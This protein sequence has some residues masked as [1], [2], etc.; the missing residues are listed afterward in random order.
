M[1]TLPY[2]R[3][4]RSGEPTQPLP[5]VNAPS[6]YE[7]QPSDI[8]RYARI[9]FKRLWLIILLIMIAEG[10]FVSYSLTR[11]PTYESSVRFKIT[12]LPPS[13][14]TLYATT[15]SSSSSDPLSATRADFISVLTS[16]DVAWDTVDSLK[17]PLSGREVEQM[18]SVQETTDSDFIILTVRAGDP[19]QSA[20]VANGLMTNAVKRYGELNAQPLSTSQLFIESQ[21]TD[22]QKS[23]DQAR[24]DLLTF[25]AKNSLGGLDAAINSEVNL[26]RSL[27]LN[28]DQAVAEGD[29]QR[30]QNYQNLVDQRQGDLAQ[31]I[32]LSGQYETLQTRVNQL[33]DTNTLLL[34]KLTEAQLKEN[35][36]RNLDSVQVFGQARVPDQPNPRFSIPIMVLAAAVAMVLGVMLAFLWEYLFP[37]RPK[38]PKAAR[39]AAT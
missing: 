27:Q 37:S 28:H 1:S 33:S 19:Q 23:L 14:V 9:I 4:P 31:M 6:V 35:E 11:P 8:G 36:A 7:N 12:S 18:V 32:N 10:A 34:G 5:G 21:I 24:T 29:A 3:S 39:S 20:D 15:R 26:I 25:E 30:A 13:D 17:L 38:K 2:S 22:T 16:L